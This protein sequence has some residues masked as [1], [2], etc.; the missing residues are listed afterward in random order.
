MGPVF[1]AKYAGKC[2][3]CGQPWRQGQPIRYAA[4]KTLV[5][6]RCGERLLFGGRRGWDWPGDWQ[7]G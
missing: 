3:H 2:R 5:H 4:A 7:Y 1:A 6:E